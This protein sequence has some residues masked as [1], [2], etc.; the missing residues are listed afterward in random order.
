MQDISN[1]PGI[2][3]VYLMKGPMRD[4]IIFPKALDCYLHF[5]YYYSYYNINQKS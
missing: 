3:T 5:Y 4:P 1:L 2:F